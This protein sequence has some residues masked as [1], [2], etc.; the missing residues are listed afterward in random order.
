MHQNKND[1]A[2]LIRKSLEGETTSEENASLEMRLH[3]SEANKKLYDTYK[4]AFELGDKYYQNTTSLDIDVDLEW[5]HFNEAIAG[6]KGKV[7]PVEL[8][9]NHTPWLKVAAAILLL[10][11]S[12][13]IVYNLL[14]KVETIVHQTA[15]TT[16][17]ITLPDNST[18]TLNSFSMLSYTSNFNKKERNLEL[19]G[20][21][22]FEVTRDKDKTFTIR[23]NEATVSVLG[24]S[25]NIDASEAD[26][27]VIVATG[28]VELASATSNKNVKLA[29]GE[30][31]VLSSEGQLTSSKNNDPNFNSWKTGIILFQNASL[32]DVIHSINKIHNSYISLGE[33]VSGECQVTVSFEKQSLESVLSV[34]EATLDLTFVKNGEK[35]I[36]SKVGC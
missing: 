1:I 34:L 16:K 30:V 19:E 14:F 3:H 24:T 15:E 29:A 12:S 31:G 4:E 2:L 32:Q 28:L 25:F 20:E 8:K 36:I 27:E 17:V 5:K 7:I 23:A 11:A 35:I 10:I 13:F 26:T 18:V 6:K 21:A 33:G 9:D 22:F